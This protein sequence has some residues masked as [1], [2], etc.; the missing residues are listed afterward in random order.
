MRATPSTSPFFALP[1]TMRSQRCGLHADAAARRG[2]ALGLRL[3]A[4]VHHACLPARV[5]MGEVGSHG[6]ALRSLYRPAAAG[7]SVRISDPRYHSTMRILAFLLAAALHPAGRRR[8]TSCPISATSPRPCFHAAA[9]ARAR[10]EHHAPDPRRT[11]PTS[12]TPSVDRL[13]ERSRL[14]AGGA[15]APSTRR[16]SSSS[17][18]GSVRQRLRAAG[19]LH[20]RP[21]RAVPHRAERIRTCERARPTKSRTSRSATSRA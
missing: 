18:A 8:P 13:P 1:A 21:H 2:E 9:G 11:G 20:R 5:E 12:T 10:R 6:R 7:A 19:R 4:H 14:P 3:A 16:T 15:A 17:C